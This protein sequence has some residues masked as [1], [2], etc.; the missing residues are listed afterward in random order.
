MFISGSSSIFILSALTSSLSFRL[1]TDMHSFH[2][3]FVG[4][5]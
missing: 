3:I 2:L 4:L 1:S 5:V